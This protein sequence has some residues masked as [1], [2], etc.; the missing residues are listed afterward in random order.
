MTFLLHIILFFWHTCNKSPSPSSE[1]VNRCCEAHLLFAMFFFV[2]SFAL[3]SSFSA[4]TGI[5]AF[6]I[7]AFGYGSN[8]NRCIADG[9]PVA[10]VTPERGAEKSIRRSHQRSWLAFR[11]DDAFNNTRQ[12]RLRHRTRICTQIELVTRLVCLSVT[13][14]NNATAEG[15][16]DE[17]SVTPP[18]NAQT[19]GPAIKQQVIYVS[20]YWSL[21]MAVGLAI[22]VSA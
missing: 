7:T 20:F 15:M 18:P 21:V 3:S 9:R 5:N 14:I 4:Q 19:V 16:I 11:K 12:A 17:G 13:K 2:G 10:E 6:L 8:I 22:Y 1:G